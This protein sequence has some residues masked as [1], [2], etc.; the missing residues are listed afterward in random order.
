MAMYERT[1]RRRRML[2]SQILMG[3]LC[4]RKSSQPLA[5]DAVPP[6]PWPLHCCCLYPCPGKLILPPMQ[7]RWWLYLKEMSERTVLGSLRSHLSLPL[8]LP[9][10]MAR[11][12]RP[13]RWEWKCGPW[14]G[15][16]MP[17][18][19]LMSFLIHSSWSLETNCERGQLRQ[20]LHRT[21]L[22][23]SL[24]GHFHDLW[25]NVRAHPLWTVLS[26]GRW[27]WV[28]WRRKLSKPW[29]ARL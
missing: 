17:L 19:N 15:M 24:W 28:V 26:L 27:F 1:L 10:L 23:T 16:L 25:L 13:Q 12:S 8:S 29:G 3:P 5:E 7:S 20:C 9:S 6:F 2:T 11:L 14:E 18:K 22:Y 21:P 4:L